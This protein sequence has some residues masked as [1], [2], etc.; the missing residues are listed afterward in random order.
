MK[1]TNLCNLNPKKVLRVNN[2]A[3]SECTEHTVFTIES[4]DTDLTHDMSGEVVSFADAIGNVE[5]LDEIPLPDCQPVVEALPQTLRYRANFDANFEDRSAFITG[6]SKYIEEA[7]RH[8]ELNEILLE[9]ERHAI[10]LYTWR[11]CSRAVPMAKSNEQPNR[12]EIYDKIVEVLQP[13][14][15]KL[16]Q[17]M[18]FQDR[19]TKRFCEEVKRLSHSEKRKDFVSEA[20]LLSL[21]KLIN[22]F[23]VLDE[24][25]NMK[26]SIKNDYS[27]YRRAAQFLQVMSDSQT[28]QESQNLSMFLATQNKIKDSLRS[29]LQAIEGY[30]ELLADVINICMHFY[31]NHLYVTP[32]EKHMLIKQLEVVPLFGDMQ[33]MPFAFIKRCASYEASRWPL[34]SVESTHC[35]INVVELLRTFRE[36]HDE[37]VTRLA[38]IHNKIAVYDK[39]VVRSV[40]ENRHLTELALQGLQLLSSWTSTVLELYSWKLLHPTDPHQSADCPPTAEEYERA[41]RYNY[42]SEEKFAIIEIISMVKGLQSLMGKMEAEFQLAI[43]KSV[44]Y[45]TQEFVQITL[46]EPLRKA[47]KNKKELIRTILQ[48]VRDTV[49]DS[50]NAPELYE[51]IY[52]TRS[53][54][55]TGSNSV[56]FHIEPRAV[57]PSSTQLYMMRTMLESLVSDRSS[58]RKTIRKDIDGQHLSII[59]EFLR[60]SHYW[61]ALLNFNEIL[62]MCCDMSQLWFREFY[63]EMTMGQRIQFPIEMSMPWILT[64]HILQTKN[65]SY[66]EC[67]LYQL[68]LYND[69]AECAMTRFE[70]QFLYD[71]VEAEVNLCF[72]QFVYR[73]SVQI[74]SHYKQLAASMLL[75]KRFKSDCSMHGVNV[76]FVFSTRYETL[77]KQRHFQLLGRSIDLNR[78]LTQRINA[79]FLKSLDLA[80]NRFEATALTGIVELDGLIHVN[81]LCHKLL[82]NHLQGLTDFDD[83]Y[84]EANHSISAPYGRITFVRSRASSNSASAAQRDKPPQASAYFF[85]GSKAFNTAFSNIYTMYCGF[86]GVPHFHAMAKLLKYNGIAVILEELLKVSENL[87]VAKLIPKVCRLPLYDYGSPGVLAFY[88][89]QLKNLIHNNDLK[90]EIF[91]ACREM[92]N[93][94]LF[95][96]WLE[97]SLS[98]EEVSDLLH[99]APFQN[100]IPR[101]YCK[102]NEKPEMKIKRLEQKYANLHVSNIM[103]RYGSE[104]QASIA[105]DC[106]LLTKER[107]CC[108]LSIFEV[109]LMRIKSFLTDPIWSGSMLP[110]NSVMT[111]DECSE[112]HRLWSALQFLYCMPPRENEITVE[113][114]FGE[115]LNWCGCALIV[116]LDQRRRFEIVDFCYHI[117]RVQRVDGCDDIVPGVGEVFESEHI[118]SISISPLAAY[119]VFKAK[120]LESDQAELGEYFRGYDHKL[121]V[122]EESIG[123]KYNRLRREVDELVKSISSAKES[124]QS[125]NTAEVLNNEKLTFEEADALQHMLK[126]LQVE[127]VIGESSTSVANEQE[128]R[129]MLITEAFENLKKIS[130]PKK[131]VKAVQSEEEIARNKITFDFYPNKEQQAFNDQARISQLESRIAQFETLLGVDKKNMQAVLSELNGKSFKEALDELK[132]Q[133]EM[134]DTNHLDT[135]EARLSAICSKI[136][137]IKEKKPNLDS[138]QEKKIEELYDMMKKWDSTCDS[139]PL[140]VDRL[141]SLQVLHEQAVQFSQ[142]LTYLDGVQ[143]DISKSL[144]NCSTLLTEVQTVFGKNMEVIKENFEAVKRRIAALKN[145]S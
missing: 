9:G 32:A 16:L 35:P 126:K 98:Q 96:L 91:Q 107:L 13:E 43:R 121:Q 139:L 40:D 64:D 45:D 39:N 92:G 69:S 138:E 118:D 61:N 46:R 67:I 55:D 140:I 94:M 1:Q 135:I 15:K 129:L 84:Q 131:D 133:V 114:L 117:L 137:V 85:W 65:P 116:L 75:D 109:I 5:L 68:D 56:E 143:Q 86:V 18:Y 48:S 29:Q 90:M 10:N 73:L 38:R 7:T 4:D 20:Y 81:R 57:P 50:S 41:T 42:S 112:F 70:K 33:V 27:T 105:Q 53:R 60:N 23:A 14:V 22:M 82:K 12:A 113:E 136:S 59:S 83:L 24:L 104:K 134:L 71:E 115:G 128:N 101:P 125:A 95:C 34:A 49:I 111:I 120:T 99:A 74:F 28:L 11:C 52:G 72:D 119:E 8:A 2:T 141:Q 106:D 47:T 19:A 87:S 144:S 88:Y 127:Q 25:K 51:D 76:P 110:A 63:L 122:S 3:K 79:F 102:E 77:M 44:Y 93:L 66:I 54:R 17:L 80:I 100:I 130:P 37:F 89:A 78:L 103:E 36:E 26:A 31:E 145:Q 124:S 142:Y 30:D 62:S 108:G 123:E 97:K 58:G 21:G 132:L 6:I